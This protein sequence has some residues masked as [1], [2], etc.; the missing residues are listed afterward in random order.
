MN[1]QPTLSPTLPQRLAI[2]VLAQ[3]VTAALLHGVVALGA[4]ERST[5]IARAL[6]QRGAPSAQAVAAQPAPAVVVATAPR[7]DH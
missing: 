5:Q 7:Q 4:P 2:A 6:L 3:C 1:T